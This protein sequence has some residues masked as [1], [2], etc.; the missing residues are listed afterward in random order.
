M[1]TTEGSHEKVNE[2]IRSGV[3]DHI[4]KPIDTERLRVVL[5]KY[6]SLE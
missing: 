1:V 3:N 2:A 4:L 6:L 5:G